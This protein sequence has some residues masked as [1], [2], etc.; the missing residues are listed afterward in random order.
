MGLKINF[1]RP[2][3]RRERGWVP[4][5][6]SDTINFKVISMFSDR[7]GR[8]VFV[9]GYL[10]QKEVTL[11]NVYIP[12]ERNNACIRD[13]FEL[14]ASEASGLYYVVTGIYRYKPNLILLIHYKELENADKEE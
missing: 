14:I 3:R 5:L 11:V 8:Y 13:I 9:K 12:P 1:I 4:T 7:E 6:I 2:I 10:D